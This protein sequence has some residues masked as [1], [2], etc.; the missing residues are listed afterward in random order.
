M[1]LVNRNFFE[2]SKDKFFY[3]LVIVGIGILCIFTI[4]A[5]QS[6]TFSPFIPVISKE[7]N[8]SST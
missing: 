6:H 2:A 8:I 1:S 3:G 4:G 5:G 7:L